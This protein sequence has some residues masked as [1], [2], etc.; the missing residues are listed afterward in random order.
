MMVDLW[1][2][3]PSLTAIDERT[4]R[5]GNC[6]SGPSGLL[7]ILPLGNQS[8]TRFCSLFCGIRAGLPRGDREPGSRRLT[9]F[10][11]PPDCSF[12]AVGVPSQAHPASG[13]KAN[14][15]ACAAWHG[16]PRS[17]QPTHRDR[18]SRALSGRTPTI[19]E[20]DFPPSPGEG[21]TM[22]CDS[23]CGASNHA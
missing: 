17:S 13:W 1:I 20:R 2:Q 10:P 21:R 14:P 7:P 4:P 3:I 19:P 18:L 16:Q 6:L 15:V 9:E 12:I 8:T 5:P 23:S 22:R 11:N